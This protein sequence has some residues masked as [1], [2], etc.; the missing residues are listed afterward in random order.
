MGRD[1]LLP[2]ARLRNLPDMKAL[3]LVLKRGKPRA[4]TIAR[5]LVP[6]LRRRRVEVFSPAGPGPVVPG[7]STLPA[8]ELAA[9]VDLL[10]VLGGDGTFLYAADLVGGRGV[11]ILG[12]NLGS[13]GFLTVFSVDETRAAIAAALRGRL[14]IE[15][16]MRLKVTLGFGHEVRAVRYAVNDAVLS[17]G[18]LARLI[19][20]QAHAA[21]TRITTYRADGLIVSTPSGSTAYTLAA[22][23]PI[24]RPELDAMVLTPICPFTLANRPL[25]LPGAT[26]LRITLGKRARNVVLTVDGQWGENLQPGDHVEMERARHPL[27]IYRSP[28]ADFFEILRTKLHWGRDPQHGGGA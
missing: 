20:L 2:G 25:V 15:E 17:Q 12:V 9:A 3:G 7:V 28:T 27:R 16:R 21:G 10:V 24:L 14:A 1:P 26:R 4:L 11:P 18:A 23:G 19:E 6:W 8:A 13:L 5:G 22:G